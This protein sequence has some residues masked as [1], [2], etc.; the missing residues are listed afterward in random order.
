LGEN[1]PSSSSLESLTLESSFIL[2][3]SI[4]I[5]KK[6]PPNENAPSGGAATVAATTR[7]SRPSLA[8]EEEEMS[9]YRTI[10][11]FFVNGKIVPENVAQRARPDQTLLQFLRDD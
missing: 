8:Y 4:I 9:S 11:R 7:I 6:M 5:R 1:Q 3:P 2:H 10:P